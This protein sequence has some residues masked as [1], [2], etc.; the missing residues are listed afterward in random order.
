MTL[1]ERIVQRYPNFSK[2]E[3]N[4]RLTEYES[5]MRAMNT[6][7]AD[8]FPRMHQSPL[9]LEIE[10]IAT[11]L[12]K[13]TY[14]DICLYAWALKDLEGF[15]QVIDVAE[16]FGLYPEMTEPTNVEDY[17]SPVVFYGYLWGSLKENGVTLY[18][19]LYNKHIKISR[20]SYQISDSQFNALKARGITPH[21]SKYD[22]FFEATETNSF[23]DQYKA[24]GFVIIPSYVKSTAEVIEQ[25]IQAVNPDACL[26]FDREYGIIIR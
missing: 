3:V 17:L 5:G 20:R 7:I 10:R 22:I 9:Y 13:H 14:G 16:A 15:E 23:V 4:K 11:P 21:C 12:Q 19:Q 18:S 8:M 25:E 26:Q 6:H 1:E 24:K 2:S